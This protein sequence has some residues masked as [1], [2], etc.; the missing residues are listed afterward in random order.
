MPAPA[1]RSYTSR[2]GIK[3]AS[4]AHIRNDQLKSLVGLNVKKTL[5]R[6]RGV[7]PRR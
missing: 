4:A 7:A 5:D 6:V 2:R 3:S 1:P